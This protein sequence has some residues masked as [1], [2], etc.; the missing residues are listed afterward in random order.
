MYWNEFLTAPAYDTANNAPSVAQLNEHCLI[1]LPT[2]M[3]II[4]SQEDCIESSYTMPYGTL[5]SVGNI[6]YN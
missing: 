3:N 4:D 2:L 1:L 5:D 6:T